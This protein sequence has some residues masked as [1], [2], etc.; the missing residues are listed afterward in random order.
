MCLAIPGRIVSLDGDMAVVDVGGAR[1]R[2]SVALI[3]APAL[4]E[5]V[6]VHTGYALSKLDDGAAAALDAS[7]DALMQAA[8]A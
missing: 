3:E 5:W 7:L 6:I 1:T 8:A 2:T 4:G